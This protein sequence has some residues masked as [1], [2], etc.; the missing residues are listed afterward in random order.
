MP[1]LNKF[2]V[3]KKVS[4]MQHFLFVFGMYIILLVASTFL[5]YFRMRI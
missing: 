5:W 1:K 2:E 4:I 3:L